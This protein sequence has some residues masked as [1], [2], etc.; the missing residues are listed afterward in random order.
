MTSDTP[1]GPRGDP[2]ARFHSELRDL[3]LAAGKPSARLLERKTGYGSTTCNDVLRGA[4]FPSWE[5]T[6][7]LVAVLGGD[8]TDWR[9]RWQEARRELDDRQR[10]AAPR[11]PEPEPEPGP[12]PT[13]PPEP[14]I[15]GPVRR[16]PVLAVLSG[17]ALVVV[18]LVALLMLLPALFLGPAEP[19]P[20]P[21]CATAR[22]YVV[23]EAGR[24]LDARGRQVG[25][26]R[27]GDALLA[28]VL[29][30]GPYRYRRKVT[31]LRTGVVGWVDLSKIRFVETVCRTPR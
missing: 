26:T 3:H 11:E 8:V 31:D 9:Y 23:T 4:R 22:R 7:A 16:H 5:V 10:A 17:L 29:D 27:P 2:V 25:E 6:E 13:A 21:S 20:E 14:R 28:E 30:P 1:P 19:A 12:A 24:L 18:I 15:R